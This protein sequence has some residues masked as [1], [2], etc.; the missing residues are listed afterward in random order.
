MNIA[1]LHSF[2]AAGVTIVDHHTASAQFMTHLANEKKIREGCPADWVWIVP[3]MSGSLTPVYHQEMAVY[4]LKPSYDYQR[5]P[6]IGYRWSEVQIARVKT[7]RSDDVEVEIISEGNP[8]K[9]TLKSVALAV[10]FIQKVTR[11]LNDR[12]KPVT[13]VFA[14]ETGKS[15]TFARRLAQSLGKSCNVKVR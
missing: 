9:T 1:V 7:F 10:R 3:P 6:W 15:E 2:K 13:I 12:K 8:R 5:A 11:F 14:T 4:S